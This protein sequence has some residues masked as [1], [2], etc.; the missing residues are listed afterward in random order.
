MQ[1]SPTILAIV[2]GGGEKRFLHF[3]FF[4]YLF[5]F[6]ILLVFNVYFAFV[7]VLLCDW[8]TEPFATFSVSENQYQNQSTL[9]ARVFPRLATVVLASNSDWLVILFN[10][11][12]IGPS[13][14]FLF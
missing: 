11:A 9:L 3:F 4:F 12:V 6:F 7:S 5:L 2:F 8:L 14:H 1:I 10:P 13:D